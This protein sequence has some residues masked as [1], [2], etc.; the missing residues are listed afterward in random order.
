M[1]VARAG[2][3]AVVLAAGAA[4]LALLVF[5]GSTARFFS[6]G[7][8][9]P[10]LASLVGGFYVASSLVF[11]VAMTRPRGEMRALLAAAFALTAP[12]F[13]ATMIHLE[14]FDLGRWQAWFWILLFGGAPWFWLGCLLAGGDTSPARP[15]GP[16][17]PPLV[18]LAVLLV[19]GAVLLWIDPVGASGP[20]PLDFSPMGGRFVGAWLA[21]LAVMAVW[22]G[23]RPDEARL[24]LLALAVYPAGALVAALRSITDLRPAGSPR[25][26]YIGA[27]AAA[28]VLFGW[29]AV[30]ARVRPTGG[31]GW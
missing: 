29:K 4:G 25:L 8:G 2:F 30:R 23:L 19:G 22:A 13:V 12:T 3:A 17:S 5:P 1:R 20:L 14:V 7:L 24:P 15:R 27:L 16:G 21:F 26:V 10:P 6:W 9:P 11:G 31:R 18:G 28:C